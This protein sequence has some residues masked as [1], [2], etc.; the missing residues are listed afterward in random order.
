MRG[1]LGDDLISVQERLTAALMQPSDELKTPLRS[2][3]V[4][5]ARVFAKRS[6]QRACLSR[7]DLW[8]RRGSPLWGPAPVPRIR[9][10][11]INLQ[12]IWI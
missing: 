3:E 5:A 10:G 7:E 12:M 6:G 2:N 8:E 1:Q 11:D 4:E 9:P